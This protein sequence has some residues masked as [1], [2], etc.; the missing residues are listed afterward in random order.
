[1]DRE[2]LEVDQLDRGAVKALLPRTPR[3]TGTCRR[4]A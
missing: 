1:M 4:Q 3:S 2:R